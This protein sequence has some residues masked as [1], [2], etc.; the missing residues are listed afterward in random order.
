MNDHSCRRED[1]AS[2]Y[3]GNLVFICVRITCCIGL[4]GER[5]LIL[6]MW[7]RSILQVESLA[8]TI[9]RVDIVSG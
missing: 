8:G 4:L 6:K 5:R 9:H 3:R 7:D 2:K 1:E